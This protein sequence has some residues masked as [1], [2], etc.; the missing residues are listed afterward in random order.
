MDKSIQV[1]LGLPDVR[2][3]ET[4]K[5]AE[6]DW[7][8]RIESTK[9]GTRCHQCG[10]QISEF[11]GLDRVIRL[12]H[13]PLFEDRVFLELRPKRYR[14]DRCKGG[15][16]TTQTLSWY[17]PRSPNTKAYERWLLRMLVNSTV[18]DVAKTLRVTDD[19]VT[20][21]LDRWIR[22]EVDWDEFEHIDVI[23]IDE[24]ALKRGHRDFVV[25]VTARLEGQHVEV[26][27]TLADR[28]K[29][30]VAAFFAA[31]P[32]R[33]KRTIKRVCSDMYQGFVGAA[34]EQLPA[35]KIVIDRFHV[36]QAYRNCADS[37]RKREMKRLKHEL[38]D[39]DYAT[40]KGSMWPFR[41]SADD[42]KDEERERLERLFFYS[43]ML[44]Q[45]YQR[46]EELTAIFDGDYTKVSATCAIR[47]WCKRVRKQH[48][49][50]FESFLQTIETWLDT[51]TNYFLERL[52]SGFVEGFNNRVKVLKRRCYGIFDVARLFQRL[53]LDTNGYEWLGVP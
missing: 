38:S 15:A 43:P 20:G 23:G 36:A 28:K 2:V 29:Q 44:K 50:A 35:A 41:K 7:L 53:S 48:I 22:S 13:L 39:S 47:A 24:I 1:P 31:I 49:Q 30:T 17:R 5:T 27:A 33:L 21:V 9:R 8:I 6:G 11:H 37:V 10:G 42:L 3:L 19:I 25:L 32:T 52:T 12:R 40:I 46:R 14:C 4:T 45:A 51:I 26:L 16:T 18:V 34:Q